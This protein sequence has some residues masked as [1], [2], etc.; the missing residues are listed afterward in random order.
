MHDRAATCMGCVDW[1]YTCVWYVQVGQRS[2]SQF[3]IFCRMWNGMKLM[4]SFPFVTHATNC[5]I[6]HEATCLYRVITC[7]T[8]NRHP[9]PNHTPKMQAIHGSRNH[10]LFNWRYISQS[11]CFN[12]ILQPMLLIM[13]V[14]SLATSRNA[15]SHVS[16]YLHLPTPNMHAHP[17]DYKII[18]FFTNLHFE[19]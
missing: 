4:L 11:L 18:T 9:N 12:P 2:Y 6:G 13:I 3:I 15:P 16:P 1:G 5:C 14:L 17:C 7:N 10:A 19:Q 8:K